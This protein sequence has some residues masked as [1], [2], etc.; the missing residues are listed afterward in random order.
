VTAGG[1][2]G[3]SEMSCVYDLLDTGQTIVTCQ[4]GLSYCHV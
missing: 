3:S 1:D 4:W 2:Y